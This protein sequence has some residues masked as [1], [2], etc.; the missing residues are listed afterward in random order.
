MNKRMRFQEASEKFIAWL[1]RRVLFAGRGDDLDILEVEPSGRFWLGRL[2][3]EDAVIALGLGDRGERLDPCATGIRVR[4][5]TESPWAFQVDV[6]LKCWFR[7]QD[8]TW[9]KSET[10]GQTI[11]VSIPDCDYGTYSFGAEELAEALQNLT[12]SDDLQCEVRVEVT[13]DYQGRSELTV[14]LVNT[15]REKGAKLADTNLYETSVSFNL[16]IEPFTLESLPDSFRYD[17]NVKAYGVNCGVVQEKGGTL[18]TADLITADR[19]RPTYWNVA[20]SEPDLTFRKLSEDPMPSLLYLVEQLKGWGNEAWSEP[21]LTRRARV[22]SWS[23]DMLTEAKSAASD[24][25]EEVDR[26]S[27]G[28]QL[29][30]SNEALRRA[31]KL[32]NSAM[33]YSSGG[34]YDSWRAFQIGYL[35]ANI[36][37]LIESDSVSVADI[38]WFATGGGKTE[39]YLGLLVTAVLFERLNGKTTGVTAWSRFPLRMLS[40]QQTQRF[41]DAMAG[42][43]LIR[44]R[45][46]IKGDPFSVGFFV[47]QDAT[48]NS[49]KPDVEPQSNDP[50]PD[51]PEM[52][53]RYQVLLYCPFCRKE[54]IEMGFNRRYW[55]LEHR[56]SNPDCSW[57]EEA[58]PFYVVDH[59]IYRFLPTIIVGTIDK[60]A[61][62]AMEAAMRGLVGPPYGKCSQ[63]GHGYVY[64]PRSQ[65]PEGCLVPGCKGSKQRLP[66]KEAGFAPSFRLQ[67]ELHLLR[68]SLGAV[69]AHYESLLDYLESLTSGRRTKV[70]A[71]SATLTGY[72]K[73]VDV[74]YDRTA[75]VFPVPPPS[76]G[77]GFWTKE[78]SQLARRFVAVA[79]RGATLEY[80]VDRTVTEL[81]LAV[82]RLVSDPVAVCRECGIDPVFA[83][84]LVSIY[85]VDVVYGNTLRDLDA[86]TRSF[87]TQIQVE[88]TI[89]SGFLTG[90][91]QFEEVRSTLK[92]LEA[93]EPSFDERLH[94]IAASSMMSHGVDIDRLNIMLMLGIPLTTAEFIQATARVGRKYP[95]LVFVFHKIA[96]ERD[97]GVYRSFEKFVSQGDRFVEAIPVTRRSR[98]VL[99]K[100]LAGIFMARILMI[101][102]PASG[103]A[104][105]TIKALRNYFRANNITADKET[106]EIISAL[107]LTDEL[108]EGLRNDLKVWMSRFFRNLDN[109]GDAAFPSDL[110]PSGKPMRSLRD[111]EEQAPIFGLLT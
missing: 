59:E 107:S 24:F 56:C 76:T 109:P 91:T 93:P 34:K 62:V 31:F 73:Q 89:N 39:T 10:I 108:D 32:M 103:T 21:S 23:Q 77:D 14:L 82:R 79:P 69:D 29:L 15:S 20:A 5:A 22:E 3:P 63:P 48:P 38:V 1:E 64:A 53:K 19:G 9:R 50:D 13:K 2:A 7:E 41:A 98:R 47:G 57:E 40:L 74:L 66:I 96:R 16:Q 30:T 94:L 33:A 100:T 78:S 58:L 54:T 101:H 51:D 49:I 60:A 104:L 106:D 102:E 90:R 36:E 85:G 52:P 70:L 37:T 87:E 71:S 55:K 86:A 97:A 95:G 46:S 28:L 8:R 35:L 45:E 26:V 110:C 68:D 11:S 92:R 111:V 99:D 43:E 17:R 105:S 83:S 65:R 12:D 4:P 72:Q 6:S 84:E 81:Q 18:R 88:G 44:R 61:S 27:K 67:D 42:A 75:R 80:A 25:Y